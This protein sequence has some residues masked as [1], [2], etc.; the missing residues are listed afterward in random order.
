M[1]KQARKSVFTTMRWDGKYSVSHYSKHIDRLSNHS[2][3]L[4]IT[5]PANVDSLAIDVLSKAFNDSNTAENKGEIGLVRLSLTSEGAMSASTR[6]KNPINPTMSISSTV[7]KVS[8]TALPAPHW[9]DSID[10]CKHGDWQPYLDAKKVV[11]ERDCKIALFIRGDAVIDATSSTPLLLDDDGV[12]WISDPIY[13]GVDSV[14]IASLIPYLSDC[15][16]PVSQGRLTK[17]LISRGRALLA[18]GTGIGV[19]HIT[20]LDGQDIGDGSTDFA[21]LCSKLFNDAIN[22]SWFEVKGVDD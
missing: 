16:I 1:V 5:L 11:D 21:M 9:G 8:A 4:G 15:G 18:V 17:Q 12:A 22:Q 10:G 14:S 7:T 13:G 20:K 3:R 2:S 19:V 6:W